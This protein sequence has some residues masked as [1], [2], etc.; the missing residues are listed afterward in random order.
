MP[1]FLSLVRIDEKNAPAEGPSEEMTERMNALLEEI[2]K[3]GVMLDTAGLTPTAEGVRVHWEGGRISVTDGP[4]TETKE[5]IGGYAL[6]Q[7]K[8]MAEA[9]EWSKRFLRVHDDHWTVTC[10]VRQIAE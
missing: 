7:C 9:V 8:D 4:F 1:R 10:E 3:A 6:S 5:V 2:T